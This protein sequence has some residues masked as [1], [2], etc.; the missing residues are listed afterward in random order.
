MKQFTLSLAL[1]A[2]LLTGISACNED[3][4]DDPTYVQS[5]NIAIKEF[6]LQ[7][8]TKV[9]SNLDSVFFSID[10]EK[11]LIFNAD[12]LPVGTDVS[13]LIAVIN[14]PN[15]VKGAVISMS[16]G[17]KREGTLNYLENPND[18]IDFSGKVTL[19]LT[20]QDGVSTKRYEIK[21][22]VHKKDPDILQWTNLAES[23]LP[24]RMPSPYAQKT[25]SLS[26][27]VISLI[28]EQDAT[29]TLSHTS[30][31]ADAK[32]EKEKWE[33]TFTPE[34]R[35]LTATDSKLYVLDTYGNLY[36]SSDGSDWHDMSTKWESI[37]GGFGESI[38]GISGSGDNLK[39]SCF[40]AGSYPETPLPE[41]FPVTGATNI[42]LFKTKWS[43][44]STAII[45]GGKDSKGNP[46]K[47]IWGFDGSN[48]AT[49]SEKVPVA[50]Q[51]ASLI[52]YFIYR[53]RSNLWIVNEYS[54]WMLVGGK[55]SDG[56]PNKTTYISYD[57]G[58]NWS[59]GMKYLQLPD[60]ALPFYSADAVVF[61]SAMDNDIYPAAWEKKNIIFAPGL[62]KLPYE[63]NGT[64]IEWNCPYIY[65]FGGI[66]SDGKLRDNIMRG[67]I[68]RMTFSPII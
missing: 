20:A 11:G 59:E 22:N 57:N 1:S 50:L 44:N 67:V 63:I 48:W 31:P 13:S 37:L 35:S 61:E 51:D 49:I 52:P 60:Y 42:G 7:A 54:I 8:N 21:V 46:V 45:A 30:N 64:T 19:T 33:Q 32:W 56:T 5:S 29:F 10:L 41:G 2:F 43:Q 14:Y 65:I 25:V 4:K 9:L 47:Q 38:L 39:I 26:G 28:Q 6:A 55:L 34:V 12:S 53:K 16:G 36:S 18:S 40:P 68:N 66:G 17:K 23:K 27:K 62:K 58:V 3:K 15:T 24:S